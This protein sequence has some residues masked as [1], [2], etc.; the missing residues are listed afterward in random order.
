M[1]I[2]EKPVPAFCCRLKSKSKSE[3][4][5]CR[6]KRDEIG[7]PLLFP[8]S[9]YSSLSRG[10]RSQSTIEK[11]KLFLVQSTQQVRLHIFGAKTPV[12]KLSKVPMC[13]AIC[14]R[15]YYRELGALHAKFK[16][17]NWNSRYRKDF[18]T[19]LPREGFAFRALYVGIYNLH[20]FLPTFKWLECMKCAWNR[21]SP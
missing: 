16:C 1:K 8:S 13:K 9:Y 11:N 7:E 20:Y 18:F 19:R 17:R 6:D 2:E 5:T 21:L 3:T 15:L 12:A 14:W 4:D 10:T